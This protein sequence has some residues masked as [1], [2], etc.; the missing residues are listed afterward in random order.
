MM[1]ILFSRAFGILFLLGLT[2][3]NL[4]AQRA[5]GEAET[6]SIAPIANA[7][8][9]Q[10][11]EIGG[12]E[13]T[14]AEYT[15]PN[16]II[17]ISGLVRGESIKI[18]GD[19]ISNA[20]R[21]L[22]KQ[23]LFVDVQVLLKKRVGDLIFLEIAVQEQ[24]RFAR[25]GYRGVK[26]GMHDDLNAVVNRYL[27]KGKAATQ[28]MKTNASKAL[29]RFFIEKGFLDVKINVE[30]EED[31]ILK[32]SVRLIF[33]IDRGKKVRIKE[34]NF[35][36]N[37][38]AKAGRLRK[39]MKNTKR[40]SIMSIFKPSK[41]I[42]KEYEAD[43]KNIVAYY[44]TIGHRDAEILKD[45]IYIVEIPKKNKVKKQLHIDITVDEGNTYHFGDIKF[46]GNTTYTDAELH[47]VLGISKGDVYNET[48]LQTRL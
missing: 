18:P 33:N 45:S 28:A 23:G 47:R 5:D 40:V 4:Y 7:D 16:G 19:D 36:G 25:H 15:D 46:R 2:T 27:M 13:V 42:K 11:Y 30:T 34:I 26:K 8:E 44:N 43:K 29:K 48:L 21:K 41:Y 10:T 38:L 20:I 22:W 31:E 24:A 1:N 17:N 32:N 37:E 3:L 12:I 39:A 9:P 6:D 14:G 35:K